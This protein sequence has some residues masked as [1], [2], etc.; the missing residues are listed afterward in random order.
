[1]YIIIW[2]FTVKEGSEKDFEKAYG[3]SGEWAMFFKNGQGYLGTELLTDIQDSGQYISVDRWASKE[4][5]D[6]FRKQRL[7]EY[8]AID[9]RMEPLM[10]FESHIGSY[11]KVD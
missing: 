8:K 10:E 4:A 1:M 11:T 3:P 9:E 6:Q 5:Y 2:K 7:D